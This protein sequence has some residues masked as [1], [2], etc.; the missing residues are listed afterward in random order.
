MWTRGVLALALFTLLA[1][2]TAIG[3]GG[4]DLLIGQLGAATHTDG[5]AHG[6]MRRGRRRLF[7]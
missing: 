5:R 7:V 1:I 6:H 3:C 2:V 4:D